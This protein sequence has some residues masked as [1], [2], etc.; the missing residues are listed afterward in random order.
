MARHSLRRRRTK[1]FIP[2]Q[3]E[4]KDIESP[5]NKESE[6]Q[7]HQNKNPEPYKSP[8]STN[9]IMF[10]STDE[11][12]IKPDP[13]PQET[14]EPSTNQYSH[15][16]RARPQKGHYKN[17]NEGFIAAIAPFVNEIIDNETF[18]EDYLYSDDLYELPPNFA[19]AGKSVSDLMMLD[20]A[21]HR[22]NAEEWQKALE[23]KIGQ[24]EKLKTWVVEDLPKGQT[25]IS[26]SEIIRVKHGP[27][28]KIQACRVRIVAGGHRQVGVNYTK[29][30]SATVKMPTVH[31]FLADTADKIENKMD[32]VK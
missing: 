31:I 21:L 24:L 11:P 19:L 16:K 32:A 28:G 15:G 14:T 30:F 26:H 6:D 25:A 8:K 4:V 20:E 5:E 12:M 23:C 1:S 18:K 9:S 17:M 27:D 3:N 13:E 7:Q 10:P 22:P 29:T 2:P